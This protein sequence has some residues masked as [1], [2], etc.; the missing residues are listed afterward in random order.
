MKKLK[1]AGGVVFYPTKDGIYFL[2][3]KYPRYWGLPKGTIEFGEKEIETAQREIK[4]ETG[5]EVKFL[6]GFL[7]KTAFFFFDRGERVLKEVI[8]FLAKAKNQKV[9]IS[10]EHEGF[11]WL[12]Y[13]DALKQLTYDND[14]R[15]L[16][17]AIKYLQAKKISKTSIPK[18]EIGFTIIEILTVLS[19]LIFLWGTISLLIRPQISNEKIRD[20]QRIADVRALELAIFSYLQTA[21]NPDLD[22]DN[23]QNSG[24]DESAPKM[25]ISIP[26]DQTDLRGYSTSDAGISWQIA[27]TETKTLRRA[28]GSGW[29][30]IPFRKLTYPPLFVLPIDPINNYESKLFYTY[31]FHRGNNTFEI[32]A[33]LESKQYQAGGA[34]NQTSKDAGDNNNLLEVGS[35]RTLITNG[36]Y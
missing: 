19:I 20:Q 24:K 25:F 32:D 6:P 35:D 5:L 34:E 13:Q 22:G 9:N 16:M 30:P 31:V 10:N 21:G 7:E 14:R 17:K 33:K 28:D 3:L 1:S 4:E 2:L 23:Y 12:P 15:L 27:Q 8:W 29:L 11:V 36:L 18:K 26:F